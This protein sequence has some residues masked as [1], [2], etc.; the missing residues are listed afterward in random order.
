MNENQQL[1]SE[2]R[3][4]KVWGRNIDEE[5]ARLKE[6][7]KRYPLIAFDTE[8]PG[9]IHRTYIDSSS[10]EW[11]IAM[12]A[13]VESTKLIQCGF[14]L[15]N[16]KGEIGGTWEINF[17]N[18]GDPSDTRNE[19]SIEFLRRHGLD[20]DKIRNEGVDMF[21]YGFFPK[22]LSA[23]RSQKN[24]EFVTFQ[25]A[26]DFAYFLCILN[27]GKLPETR[28]EF[29]S[30]V[31]KVFGD[32]YDL[33]VMAGFCEGLG[34]HLGLSK[35]AQLL[36]IARVGRAHHAGSDSLMTAL[37]FSKL[38]QVYEDSNFAKGMLYGI[39]KRMVVTSTTPELASSP[40]MCQQSLVSYPSSD[41]I[42]HNGYVPNYDQSQLVGPLVYWNPSGIQWMNYNGVYVNQLNQLPSTTFPYPS[43]TPYAADYL[44]PLPNYLMQ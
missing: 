35:L 32:V 9:I 2:P 3:T 21:G 31:V 28:G 41:L 40:V 12:K 23:F 26:Y 5:M 11:Y 22:L 29:A 38:K 44:G 4:T 27:N 7:L 37:V 17:S 13:N 6:C 24:V 42:Y 33:K 16:A 8:Y 20:L 1:R 25:G 14:T 19:I 39:G 34:E 30:E 43:Q 15:F 10:D 18:F 36:K